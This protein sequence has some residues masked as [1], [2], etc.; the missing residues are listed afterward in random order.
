MCILRALHARAIGVTSQR[1]TFCCLYFT[2]FVSS[3]LPKYTYKRRLLC[4]PRLSVGPRITYRQSNFEVFAAVELRVPLF[5]AHDAA[6]QRYWTPTYRLH[7]QGYESAE[8]EG[9]TSLRNVGTG[10]N[11]PNIGVTT[12][13]TCLLN[14]MTSL[15]LLKSFPAV[16]SSG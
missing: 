5:L 16:I 2:K 8:G 6:S 15:Q 12:Q 7:S 11:F 9:R 10:H 14:K 13:K 4:A 3:A 1:R